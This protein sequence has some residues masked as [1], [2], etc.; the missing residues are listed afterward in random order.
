MK[1]KIQDQKYFHI[2]CKKPRKLQIEP[3]FHWFFKKLDCI[4]PIILFLVKLS[5]P[6][7]VKCLLLLYLSCYLH[8]TCNVT[9]LLYLQL[10]LGATWS[11]KHCIEEHHQDKHTKVGNQAKKVEGSTRVVLFACRLARDVNNSDL[12]MNGCSQ[13]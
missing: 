11:S 1:I 13:E 9:I 8:L 12:G 5:S 10:M 2:I 3:Q 4:I 6:V 7:I